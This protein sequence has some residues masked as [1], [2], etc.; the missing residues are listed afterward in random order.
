MEL[1]Y[2]MRHVNIP[3]VIESWIDL[4]ENFRLDET[5]NQPY[6]KWNKRLNMNPQ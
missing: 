3:P 5:W 1:L 6:L 2:T 4:P